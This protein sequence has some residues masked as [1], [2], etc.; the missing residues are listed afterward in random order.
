MDLT[1]AHD[2]NIFSYATDQARTIV[3]LHYVDLII[4]FGI[5]FTVIGL[6][7]YATIKFKARPGDAEPRQDE[8]N[9]KLEITWTVIPALILL[10]LGVLTA[11]VMNSVNPPVG[12]LQADVIVN[13]HQFWW[14]YRY[15]K[16][17]VVT[18]NEL[19]LPEGVNTLLEIRSADVIHSFW[20]PDFGQKMD[21]VPGHPNHLFLKPFARGLFTG[22]CSE[23]CGAAHSLMRIMVTVLSPQD[24]K[25][26]TE[27][28]LKVPAAPTETEAVHGQELFMSK[29]CVQCH[30]IAGTDAKALVGPNLTHLADR[31]TLA[32]GMMA[33]N[34]DNAAAWIVNPQKYKPGCHM[35]KMRISKEE[36]HDIAVYLEGLK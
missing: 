9:V 4:C 34:V 7:T 30:A 26:W 14:E 23:F 36:A 33:N 21:A 3:Y 20:V 35:P 27:S 1:T 31:K 32:A 25:A 28:Q 11:I 12:K 24:F 13:A 8:G 16:T 10:F 17:G 2:T 6:V 22:A 29:T 5:L 15:P 18:A 19:Y